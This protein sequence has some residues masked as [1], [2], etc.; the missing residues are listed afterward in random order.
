MLVRSR[1]DQ[2]QMLSDA[3]SALSGIQLSSCYNSHL[4]PEFKDIIDFEEICDVYSK[5]VDWKIKFEK[6]LKIINIKVGDKI[7]DSNLKSEGFIINCDDFHNIV[8]EYFNGGSGLY[9]LDYKCNDYDDS[10][11]FL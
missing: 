9:C 3:A 1:E 8:V 2:L 5:L 6:R 11:I 10:L 4:D 7:Y